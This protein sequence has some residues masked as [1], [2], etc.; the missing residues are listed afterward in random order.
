VVAAVGLQLGE[1]ERLQV[2]EEG[3]LSYRGECDVSYP[4]PELYPPLSSGVVVQHCD[5]S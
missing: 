1:E 2:E 5:A 4:S 3:Q